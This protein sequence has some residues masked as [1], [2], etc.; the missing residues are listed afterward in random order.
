MPKM[1]EGNIVA[2][3]MTFAIIASGSTISSAAA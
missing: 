3:G 2:Q 1:I